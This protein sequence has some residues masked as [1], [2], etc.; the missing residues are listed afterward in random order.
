MGDV[1]A[2][3]RLAHAVALDGLGEDHGRL[4]LVLHRRRV[5][6]I[7]LV[8]IVAAAVQAP[9]LVVGHVRDHLAAAPDTCRRNACARTRRRAA[10]NAWYSPS[11][12]SS[13]RFSSRP[14]VSR[15]MSGSQYE[16]QITLITFQPAPRK[17]AS[18]SWMIL[19]LPR[20]GPS[21][22]CRLQLTTKIRLSSFSRRGERDRAQR[23]RLV[24]LAVAHERPDLAALG[25]RDAAVLQ[26]AHEA[27][28]VD[29]HDRAEPHGYGRELP[30]IGHEPRMRIGGEPLA[31]DFLAE[32]VQLLFADAA[33]EI[34]ARVDA[35]RGMALEVDEVAAEAVVRGAEEMVEA[36]VV[37]RR[38]RGEARD[39]AAELGGFLVRAHHHRHRVPAHERAEL[40]LE[41]RVAR[42]ALLLRERDRVEVGGV[43]VIRNVRAAAARLLDQLLEQ[44]IG[45]RRALRA[46]APNRALPATPAFPADRRRA[47]C[48]ACP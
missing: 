14:F 28:L 43:G 11:T 1:L 27:R 37:Q 38:G 5:G 15:M 26:V 2:F 39:V 30:E 44:E 6:G 7:D 9:D 21:R 23:L 12:A 41:L 25:R 13:M 45:A 17:S 47:A 48:L 36:D 34:G 10:L 40:V 22:R 4:A 33:L 31:A 20:T 35:G 8:R 29:R 16:P 32:V 18:S 19:P 3:A 46:R 24:H 42:R